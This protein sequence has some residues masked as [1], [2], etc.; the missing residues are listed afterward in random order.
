MVSLKQALI[1]TKNTVLRPYDILRS[2]EPV[3]RFLN[4]E[5]R[6]MY[7]SGPSMNPVRQRIVNDLQRDGIA[8]STLEDLFPEK[9]LLADLQSRART[10]AQSATPNTKKTYL[11]QLIELYPQLDLDDVF[12]RL[13]LSEE[14]MNC[15][16]GYL[17]M[18]PKLYYYT[19]GETRPVKDGEAPRQSQRWHRDP[20]DRQMCKVFVYLTDVDQTAG[21]FRYVL[22][23]TRGKRWGSFFPQRPPH[24]RYPP[25]GAVEERI[26]ESDILTCTG[27]A[28][29]VIF[30]DTS[31]L[32]QGG[33]AT[34]NA[35]IMSTTGFVTKACPRGVF[36]TRGSD[37]PEKAARLSP[38][39]QYALKHTKI[40]NREWKY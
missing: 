40:A 6:R 24:G 22:A 17:Q 5:P 14:F 7:G 38:M 29:T 32:H 35:R 3:W 15:V 26:P 16:S 31:G 21:P 30:A 23:S 27:S 25:P 4:R 34:E 8:I 18:W 20:E 11:T 28:G 19:L 1:N 37:F 39:A 13:A 10:L 12:V 2:W 36:Y 33:Y 9:S